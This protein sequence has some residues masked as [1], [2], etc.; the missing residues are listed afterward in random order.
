MS[1]RPNVLLLYTDQQRFD[2]IGCAGNT[3]IKTPNLDRLAAS[4]VRFDKHFVQNPLCMPSR[5]SMLSGQYPTNVGITEMGRPVPQ[6]TL[7]VQHLLQASGYRTANIGKLHFLPHSNRDHR[8]PHPAYGFDHLELSEEPGCYDDA[9]RAH[10][11]RVCPEALP[12]I[13]R[14][15]D[16][17]A[18][19]LWREATG[20]SDDIERPTNLNGDVTQV[21]DGPEEATHAAFVGTQTMSFLD[22]IGDASFFCISGFYSPHSPLFAPQRYLDLYDPADLHPPEV[23][24]AT[25]NLQLERGYDD[26][27]LRQA[28]RGYFAMISEVDHWVGRILDK[29]DE[30]GQRDNTLIVFTSDHGEFLGDFARFA[31]GYPAPEC[32][33]RVPLIVAGPGVIA[34]RVERA[35]VE[36]VDVVP[37]ILELCG[38]PVPER[39]NGTPLTPALRGEP[40]DGKTGVLMEDSAAGQSWRAWRTSDRRYLL[41]ADGREMLLDLT[42]PFG[43]YDDVASDPNYAS[44]LATLRHE[45]AT[46]MIDAHR[47]LRKTWAY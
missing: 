13:G 34:G 33:G 14:Y 20:R 19:K 2:A 47:P 8:D 23:P 39:M 6:E 26:A 17:P 28:R 31:K 36:A 46:K 43:E 10:V 1:R 32:I 42:Q 5:V 38:V 11:R 25:R 30:T 40:F 7:C 35:L 44:D 3:Q 15:V 9:Y 22:G 41:H 37:T 18:A 45:L 29:L 12:I 21:F 24:E 4:G 27:F 16:P